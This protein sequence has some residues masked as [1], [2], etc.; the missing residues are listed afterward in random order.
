[1]NIIV[2]TEMSQQLLD[3]ITKQQLPKNPQGA[4]G[5]QNPT[6]CDVDEHF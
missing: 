2:C 5:L 6:I 4:Q 1:M 3:C